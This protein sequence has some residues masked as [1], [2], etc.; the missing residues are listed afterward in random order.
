[1]LLL[2]FTIAPLLVSQTKVFLGFYMHP[3][4]ISRKKRAA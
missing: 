4:L 3:L 2:F 1:M